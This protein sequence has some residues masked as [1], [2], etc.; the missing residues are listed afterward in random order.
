MSFFRPNI[1]R[2]G[3]LIRGLAGLASLGGAWLARECS[4]WVAGGLALFGAFALFEAVR[5]WCV[6]RACGIKT[7]W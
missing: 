6:V 7:K 4:W 5:G 3:R 2:S 1:G